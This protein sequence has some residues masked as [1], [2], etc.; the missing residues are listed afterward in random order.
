[1]THSSVAEIYARFGE[2]EARGV[3][4]TYVDWALGVAEDTAVQDLLATLPRVRR[5][6]NLVFAAARL[7]GA[8]T[9]HYGEFRTW[10]LSHWDAVAPEILRR[11]TQ[12]NEAARCAVLLP[13]LSRLTG[14]LALIEV[15]ASAGLCLYPDRYSYLYD[16]DGDAVRLDP[17]GRASSLT[18]PCRITGPG[19]PTRLPEVVWRAGID[20]NPL[21][22]SDPDARRWLRALVWPEHEGRRA[23]LDTAL[24]IA[25]ADPPHLVRGNLV[26]ELPELLASVPHGARAV[27]FHSSVLVYLDP[28]DRERLAALL[29]SRPE[30]TWISNEG[31]GVLP[32]VAEQLSRPADGRTVVAVDERPV[33]LAGPHGQSYEGL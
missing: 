16:V 28:A 25:A 26:E 6:P 8:P 29:R 30:V 12:T 4:A 20:L 31:R 9:D 5:Q 21:S 13:V 24:D 1:M 33:A 22:P 17:V 14:P 7:C 15:G 27:V 11:S 10:L 23:R 19:V 32:A 2:Y 3:S 18:L